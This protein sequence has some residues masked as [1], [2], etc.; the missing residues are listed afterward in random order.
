MS[1]NFNSISFR[2]EV[3]ERTCE[4]YR[5]GRMP[6]KEAVGVIGSCIEVIKEKLRELK[7]EVST[8]L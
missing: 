1:E 6:A 8:N 4:L 5:K 3:I 7:N 2:M